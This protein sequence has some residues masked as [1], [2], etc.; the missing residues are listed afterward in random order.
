M[1]FLVVLPFVLRIPKISRLLPPPRLEPKG[2]WGSGVRVETIWES[3]MGPKTLF[4]FSAF[5]RGD[6][7][8]KIP[9]GPNSGS[10]PLHVFL[11]D[12]L[13]DGPR[14]CESP[15]CR[16]HKSIDRL[17]DYPI[18]FNRGQKRQTKALTKRAV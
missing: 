11:H 10:I 7:D 17:H 2:A 13:P 6:A 8:P 9:A 3:Q 5:Q 16:Y 1:P 12:F 4:N 18:S 15:N 14:R